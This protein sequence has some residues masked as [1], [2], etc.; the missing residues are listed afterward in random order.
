MRHHGWAIETDRKEIIVESF[1][2]TKSEAIDACLRHKFGYGADFADAR[3]K[4]WQKL[5]GRGYSA[6][7][8][9]IPRIVKFSNILRVMQEDECL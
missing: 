2:R 3:E 9:F 4:N 6:V 7:K 1:E 5:R 8:A